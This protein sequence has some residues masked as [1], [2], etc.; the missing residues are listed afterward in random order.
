MNAEAAG[1]PHL[2]IDFILSPKEWSEPMKLSLISAKTWNPWKEGKKK[3]K[4]LARLN[5]DIEG[6]GNK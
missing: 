3:D 4:K 5:V 6:I 1:L 2:Y